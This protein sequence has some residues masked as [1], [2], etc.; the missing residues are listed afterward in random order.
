MGDRYTRCMYFTRI[1][2]PFNAILALARII[3]GVFSLSF[4]LFIQALF[5][6]GMAL[7]KHT[8]VRT[9]GAAPMSEVEQ[10]IAQLKSYRSIGWMIVFSSGTFILF[11][12]VLTFSNTEIK[13][14]PHIAVIIAT[15]TF[16]ELV[17]SIQGIVNARKDKKLIMEA[18]KLTNFASALVSLA[19]TQAALLSFT[20]EGNAVGYNMISGLIF[21][22]L[23]VFIGLYMILKRRLA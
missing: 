16:T 12:S 9:H 19:M 23:S 6:I 5:N 14:D 22:T 20:Y 7:A 3:L 15:V 1:A 13:Y 4:I 18:V 11:C 8:A 2:V 17:L 10:Q 21:G